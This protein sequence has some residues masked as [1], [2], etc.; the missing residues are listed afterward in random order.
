MTPDAKHTDD[1]HFWLGTLAASIHGHITRQQPPDRLRRDLLG[2]LKSP[3]AN[4]E[5]REMLRRG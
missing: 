1:P 5:L 2:F 4:P 3:A